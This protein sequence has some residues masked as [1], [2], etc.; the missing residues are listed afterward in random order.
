MSE[1]VSNTDKKDPNSLTVE[2]SRLTKRGFHLTK[3]TLQK[4]VNL[5]KRDYS[6]TAFAIPSDVNT[7]LHQAI[8]LVER[9]AMNKH[10]AFAVCSCQ[11]RTGNTTLTWS[12]AQ[13][14]SEISEKKIVVVEAN[15]QTPALSHAFSLKDKPGLKEFLS[16]NVT[17]EDVVQQPEGESFSVITAGNCASSSKKKFSQSSFRTAL[18][19]IRDEF[20][21]TIVD[22]APVRIH[23]DTLSV[24]GSLDGLILVLEAEKDE[25]EVAQLVKTAVSD[26][27]V[28]ILGVVLNRTPYYIPDWLY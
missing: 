9:L 26:S 1:S 7:T 5:G 15:M 23:S 24:T 17:L 28:D 19:Q 12:I 25:W 22:T 13:L 8:L 3:T 10:Y 20:E 18:D 6:E 11:H 27:G 4:L 21:I 14:F 16:A 2:I